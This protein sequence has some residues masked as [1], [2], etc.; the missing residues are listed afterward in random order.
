MK[1]VI[2]FLHAITGCDTMSSMYGKGKKTAWKIL[3]KIEQLWTQVCAFNIETANPDEVAS[4]SEE[5]IK[6]LYGGIDCDSL[7]KLRFF[8]LNRSV[9]RQSL[10]DSFDLATLPPTSHAARLHCLRSCLQ[11]Q[12]WL[13]TS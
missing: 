5:F 13:G 10:N 4:S 3:S 12:E 6:Q 7:D 2:L 9:A 11:V 1:N 8:S